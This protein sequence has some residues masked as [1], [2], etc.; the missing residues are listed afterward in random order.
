MAVTG[1]WSVASISAYRF[2]I[3]ISIRLACIVELL[4]PAEKVLN[5]WLSHKYH[6]QLYTKLFGDHIS[7]LSFA[8]VQ[9]SSPTS[10]TALCE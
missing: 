2:V 9:V 3:H 1:R 6:V 5:D 8:V 10:E 4:H 7:Y